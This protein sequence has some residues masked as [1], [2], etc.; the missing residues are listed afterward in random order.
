MPYTIYLDR[1]AEVGH[2]LMRH[3]DKNSKQVLIES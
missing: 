3:G 2:G 1:G